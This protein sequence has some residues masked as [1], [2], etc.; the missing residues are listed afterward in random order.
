MLGTSTSP[1]KMM[2]P[3]VF[4][5]G[6]LVSPSTS[7]GGG[8]GGLSTRGTAAVGSAG[9]GNANFFN[10]STP[11]FTRDFFLQQQQQQQHFP[12]SSPGFVP[13]AITPLVEDHSGSSAWEG[14]GS[15]ASLSLETSGSY[16]ESIFPTLLP[17][18]A[19]SAEDVGE[20]P[21]LLYTKLPASQPAFSVATQEIEVSSFLQSCAHP[22]DLKM[23]SQ[24]KNMVASFADELRSLGAEGTEDLETLSRS[25]RRLSTDLGDARK[26]APGNKQS[27]RDTTEDDPLFFDV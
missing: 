1:P 24:S 14:A 23:F 19:S 25:L 15:L 21:G 5:G 7:G 13:Q 12:R 4:S 10:F 11:P 16:S 3:P 17:P 22:P 8:G 2:S 6:G 27:S 18:S 26:R 9:K 20:I